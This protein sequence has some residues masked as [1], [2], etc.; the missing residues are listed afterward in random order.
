MNGNG[1]R[2]QMGSVQ[3]VSESN[4]RAKIAANEARVEMPGENGAGVEVPAVSGDSSARYSSG[5]QAPGTFNQHP[6]VPG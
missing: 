3:M 4:G 1:V 2:M 6:G 5:V